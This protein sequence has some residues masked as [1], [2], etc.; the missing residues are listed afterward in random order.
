[1]KTHFSQ[2][3]Y[4]ASADAEGPAAESTIDYRQDV[5]A[6]VFQ[7]IRQAFREQLT[8]DQS[9]RFVSPAVNVHILLDA[10][11]ADGYRK[12]FQAV[13][14]YQACAVGWSTE[15]SATPSS[16]QIESAAVGVAN[17]IL[18][19]AEPP[20]AMLLDDGTIGAF[21]RRGQNYLSIDFDADEEHP[22][23][24]TDGERYWAGVWKPSGELP[25]AFGNELKSIT[26]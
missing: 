5:V 16:K 26:D 18:A 15:H 7:Q 2:I 17:L 24:G 4:I 9:F 14:R 23:A 22:W 13:D 11:K 20:S 19:G 6:S 21:W 8:R 1:M 10:R 25:D 12:F 3:S